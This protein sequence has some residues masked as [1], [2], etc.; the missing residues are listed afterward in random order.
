MA[1]AVTAGAAALRLRPTDSAAADAAAPTKP[2]GQA[3]VVRQ[4]LTARQDV[5]GTLGYGP[6]DEVLNQLAGTLTGAAAAGTTVQRGQGLYS[7]DNRMVPLFYGDL[8]AWRRLV[9]GVPDGPDVRQLEA[10]LVALGYAT[11]AEVKVD[12][13]FTAATAA[14][15]KK[16]QQA[17]GVEQTGAVEPGAVVFA[18]GAVRI[19]AVKEAKGAALRPGAPVLEATGTARL[20]AVDLDASKQALVKV[21]DKVEVRLPDGRTIAGTVS[22]VATVAKTSGG[23]QGGTAKTVLPVE[24]SLDDPAAAGALDEAPV[25]VGI[26]T[27]SRQAVL[28]VPVNAL[29][30]LAEG[31][32]GV[33]VIEGAEAHILAVKTGLFAKGSVEVSGDGLSEGQTVEV[34]AS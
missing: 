9:A 21:G 17:L 5:D 30:A 15:I 19:K 2:T 20:V 16:W 1:L 3:K 26:V 34:P 24:I 10:N 33:R 31:G 8:P 32:Y 28:T 23:G 22:T 11:D 13:T 7:V 25:R 12:D 6:A 14:A 18:P 27:A 29:L 4:D